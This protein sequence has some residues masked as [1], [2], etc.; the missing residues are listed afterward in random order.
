MASWKKYMFS[1]FS[2][3]NTFEQSITTA[4]KIF[5]SEVTPRSGALNEPETTDEGSNLEKLANTFMAI[6]ND[7]CASMKQ[8]TEERIDK[9]VLKPLQDFE[10]TYKRKAGLVM[11]DAF[12]LWDSFDNERL[13]QERA[14][15]RYLHNLQY[16]DK[17]LIMV[18]KDPQLV[19]L[20]SH[21][22]KLAFQKKVALD[23]EA[24]YQNSVQ[25][26]NKLV[27]AV[28]TTYRKNLNELQKFDVQHSTFLKQNMC[29]ASEEISAFVKQV[30]ESC[31]KNAVLIKEVEVE[32][33]I[34]AMIAKNKSQN[35]IFT[36][37]QYVQFTSENVPED[38]NSLSFG[39]QGEVYETPDLPVSDID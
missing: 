22:R 36:N 34:R 14:R 11:A 18:K 16:L 20:E 6:S 27:L 9:N 5:K 38:L 25:A 3:F 17:L 2:A 21:N 32:K 8:L 28:H 23:C 37:V 1:F 15:D 10:E 4:T 33:D 35:E 29:K 7:L 24:K 13:A 26:V 30:D 12:K 39:V 19:H 31:Q